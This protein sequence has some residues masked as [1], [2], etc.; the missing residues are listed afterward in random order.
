MYTPHTVHVSHW[1]CFAR[2]I[3]LY[4]F[5]FFAARGEHRKVYEAIIKD[6]K[7]LMIRVVRFIS[8]G[9]P[10]SGKTTFWRRLMDPTVKMDN[11]EPSTGVANEQ[12]TVVIKEEVKVDSA[13]VTSDEWNILD[14]GGY[15]N[16]LLEM[17]Q[18]LAN[19]N[20]AAD[21]TVNFPVDISPAGFS[22]PSPSNLSASTPTS[23]S[24]LSTDTSTPVSDTH[25]RKAFTHIF[26][27]AVESNW[28]PLKCALENITLVSS[29]D[30]GGHA[31]FLDMHAALIN[32]PSS[33]AD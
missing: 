8:L 33:L 32:G 12:R 14:E 16:M 2:Q 9:I 27:K 31:E 23:D 7:T 1:A 15:A 30:T 11:H 18:L 19:S 22:P 26:K 24:V 20:P 5:V 28:K 6:K 17:F 3:R 25:E 29:I 13:V 10:R 4:T 21:S